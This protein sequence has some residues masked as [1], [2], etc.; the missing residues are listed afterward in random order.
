MASA[1]AFLDRAEQTLDFDRTSVGVPGLESTNLLTVLNSAVKEYFS[2]FEKNGEPPVLLKKEKGFTLVEDTE[3]NGDLSASA[4]SIVLDD[5]SDFGSS[6]AIAIWEK[7]R[8]DYI[9]FSLNNNTTTLSTLS[10]HNTAHEDEDTVSL[11]YKLP[12]DFEGFRSEEGFEDG[13]SVDGQPFFFTSGAPSGNKFTIYENANDQYLHF[14]RGLTGFV[15]VRYNGSPTEVTIESDNV[16]IP[17]KDEDY[18]MWALVKYCAAKLERMY[19]Y[20]IAEKEMFKILSSAHM[21]RNIGKRA[22]TRPM[23]R[24]VSYSRTDIFD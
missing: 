20:G 22:R 16:D 1:S 3:L 24:S 2:S 15:F 21:R 19:W 14:P 9:E 11:L 12:S 13:V 6:G 7:D 18:A 5:S 23:R 17:S 10:G 8:A 4:V